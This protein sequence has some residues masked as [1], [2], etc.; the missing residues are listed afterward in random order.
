MYN[1]CTMYIDCEGCLTVLSKML[2]PFET[3]KAFKLTEIF[4]LY[5]FMRAWMTLVDIETCG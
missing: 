3:R 4:F 2:A 5:I 1:V